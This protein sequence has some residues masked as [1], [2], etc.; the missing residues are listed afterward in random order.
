MYLGHNSKNLYEPIHLLPECRIIATIMDDT[1]Q[2]K[3]NRGLS[4]TDHAIITCDR[5]ELIVSWD[6]RAA[7]TFG[8][9][10]HEAI[11]QEFFYLILPPGP[12]SV[13]GITL[14]DIITTGDGKQAEQF[15][16]FRTVQHKDG[17]SFDAHLLIFTV[18][19]SEKST[20]LT[21]NRSFSMIFKK[22][23]CNHLT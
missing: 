9:T 16:L 20:P 12:Q 23:F 19:L 21:N 18:P 11:G 5:D 6:N 1:T 4:A 10:S 2:T 22:S 13:P 7:K 3:E 8:W 14:T 17:S 15:S